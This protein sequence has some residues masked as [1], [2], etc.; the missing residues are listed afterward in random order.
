MKDYSEIWHEILTLL[1]IIR[2]RF[3]SEP[4]FCSSLW[5]AYLGTCWVL[6]ARPKL[7]GI[8]HLGH[9]FKG[10]LS[11]L[12]QR[13]DCMSQ[14]SWRVLRWFENLATSDTR[15]A[16]GCW[17]LTNVILS[18][19]KTLDQAF[20]AVWNPQRLLT[21]SFSQTS[22]SPQRNMFSVK[23]LTSVPACLP[24]C[25]SS[26]QPPLWLQCV[27]WDHPLASFLIFFPVK[28]TKLV[29]RKPFELSGFTYLQF[30]AL[31]FLDEGI[32]S[33]KLGCF[34]PQITGLQRE[35][36]FASREKGG[37][38]YWRWEGERKVN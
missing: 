33:N 6:P 4:S 14:F 24:L 8:D 16:A 9:I 30:R 10:M 15:E 31:M 7:I 25:L 3:L 23:F 28:I 26:K 22:L 12:R 13:A 20:R 29:A 5:D 2:S 19:C 34:F 18:P 35:G 1:K 11:P 17:A 37:K 36:R 21:W 32:A 38:G 27:F